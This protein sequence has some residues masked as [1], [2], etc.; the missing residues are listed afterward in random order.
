[1]RA[2]GD[3]HDAPPPTLDTRGR[4]RRAPVVERAPVTS[5]SSW[6]KVDLPLSPN[7]LCDGD[8]AHTKALFTENPK[9]SACQLK[10]VG[11]LLVEQLASDEILQV[12]ALGRSYRG[13]LHAL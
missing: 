2:A 10:Y 11:L 5:P 3:G 1:M 7:H 4:K 6:C 12:S 9:R 13:D 8:G